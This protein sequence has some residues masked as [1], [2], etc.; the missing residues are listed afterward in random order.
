MSAHLNEEAFAYAFQCGANNE[1]PEVPLWM[2]DFKN[3]LSIDG[4]RSLCESLD[5]Y[6]QEGEGW[7]T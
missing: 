7:G 3:K 5:C 1:D 4:Q 6:Q 2:Q